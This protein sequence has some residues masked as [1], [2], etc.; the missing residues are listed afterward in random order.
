MDFQKK[1][2]QTVGAGVAAHPK[3]LP[4]KQAVG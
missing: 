3:G 1:E 4:E 2:P